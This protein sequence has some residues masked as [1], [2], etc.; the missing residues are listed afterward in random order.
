MRASMLVH[1]NLLFSSETKL[2]RPS[3]LI[4]V[5]VARKATEAEGIT[6]FEL[7]RADGG[8]LPAFEPGAHLDIH[9]PSGVVRQYSLCNPSNET[10]RYQIAVLRDPASR[11]GSE[12]MHATV[13]EGDL[14]K[15][16]VPRNHFPL[17][18]GNGHTLLMGGGIGITPVLCM[19][20]QLSRSGASFELHYCTRSQGRT[21]FYDALR[22]GSFAADV[23]FHFDD[24]SAE[25]R[26]NIA[27]KL[28]S[29]TSQTH[30]Y[31]CG[32][33]GFMDAVLGKARELGWPESRIHYEYFGAEVVHKIDD[34][35]FEVEIA[36]TGKVISIA[37][38]KSITTALAEAGV[39]IP[40][41]C[42]QGVC[43]TCLTRVVAGIPDHRDMY[44]TPAEQALNDQILPCCS[45]S[46]STRLVLDL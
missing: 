26:L 16:S 30:L 24:G 40:L 8:D 5:R 42:E 7:V 21:A 17:S 38:D 1:V 15:I 32:P 43:G 13:G 22:A 31:V 44:L 41:S 45:R 34:G 12:A 2:S 6:S 4:E 29:C 37:A 19:A 33:K 25:Q 18:S 23:H 14:L 35:T 3:E 46:K 39:E 28:S 11:G 10:H 36:S 20:E 9:I 27:Q